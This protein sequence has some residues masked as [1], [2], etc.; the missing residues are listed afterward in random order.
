MES[1]FV[2]D[3]GADSW[4]SGV[5]YGTEE[6]FNMEILMKRQKRYPL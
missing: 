5:N 3:L 2:D 4:I 1:S 6:E